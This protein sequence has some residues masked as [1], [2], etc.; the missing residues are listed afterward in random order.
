MVEVKIEMLQSTNVV[1]NTC[2]CISKKVPKSSKK[3]KL[4]EQRRLTIKNSGSKMLITKSSY[5]IKGDD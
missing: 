5:V 4:H 2:T 1:I 3:V